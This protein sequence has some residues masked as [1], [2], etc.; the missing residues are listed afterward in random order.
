MWDGLGRPVLKSD[1]LRYVLLR[2]EWHPTDRYSRYLMML[3]KGGLY[4]DSD[5][6]PLSHPDLWGTK[7]EILTPPA[8]TALQRAMHHLD[9]KHQH[10]GPD[11]E[12][13]MSE[14]AM[15]KMGIN[16]PKVN[17][18]ISIEY[19]LNHPRQDPRYGY[20]RDFQIVQWT[21]M[22]SRG[23]ACHLRLLPIHQGSSLHSQNEIA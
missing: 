21:F 12:D 8:L 5:T 16:N 20:T 23:R 14:A 19:D 9:P 11:L 4:T 3:V 2:P 22:V 7:A 15:A 6:A 1:I 10:T 18:V 17:L 13:D